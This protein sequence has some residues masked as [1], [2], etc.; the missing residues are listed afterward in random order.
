MLVISTTALY[1]IG[2]DLI[3]D[4]VERICGIVDESTVWLNKSDMKFGG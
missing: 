3:R 1:C 2:D 4:G